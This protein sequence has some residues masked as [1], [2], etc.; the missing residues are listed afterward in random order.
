MKMS[1]KE[2]L[3]QIK[4]L[5]QQYETDTY[6]EN[7]RKKRKFIMKLAKDVV[8]CEMCG[9]EECDECM[10]SHIS[11]VVF[12]APIPIEFRTD[13][14]VIL[15][16]VSYTCENAKY[17]DIKMYEDKKFVEDLIDICAC[18]IKYAPDFIKN[19]KE[20][21]TYAITKD[22][23]ALQY[24][25]EEILNDYNFC[26]YAIYVNEMAIKFIKNEDVLKIKPLFL[27]IVNQHLIQCAHEDILDDKD[28]MLEFLNKFPLSLH[29][30]SA[31]I[32]ND[33]DV[34]SQVVAKYPNALIDADIRLWKKLKR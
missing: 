30:A 20:L 5:E 32:R 31:K 3:E 8:E 10:K 2:L 21:I 33:I 29:Y 6:N 34:V 12:L 9:D 14:E 7:Y 4:N 24:A 13:K 23:K 18:A 27:N 28:F 15:P 1:L 19:D 25:S 17:I 11:K 22:I 16:Y 26:L